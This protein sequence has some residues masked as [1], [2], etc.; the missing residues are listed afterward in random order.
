DG[1]PEGDSRKQAF[2]EYFLP[3]V[4]DENNRIAN[5]RKQLESTQR[6]VKAG[7]LLTDEQIL[8]LQAISEEFGFDFKRETFEMDPNQYISNLLMR[9][10]E[11]PVA[12]AIAQSAI[13]SGWGTSRFSVQGNNFF[14]HMCEED[15]CGISSKA[16]G[17]NQEALKFKSP[18]ESVR[19]Y[20][21]NLN[22]NPAYTNL[23]L[24][25]AELRNQGRTPS[26]CMLANGLQN[27]SERGKSY[28]D[29]VK[30]MI[31]ANNL[32][33][34]NACKTKLVNNSRKAITRQARNATPVQP[35]QVARAENGDIRS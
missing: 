25:R 19:S 9:V 8:A 35:Y 26:G 20:I 18:R 17:P 11:V 28:V 15:G 22:S 33:D 5:L 12:L 6:M 27:Y 32:E 1:L 34:E 29:Q 31:R 21:V 10:D 4:Q 3:L 7:A 23:R 14:G 2:I 30:S 13:E 16:L 24:L